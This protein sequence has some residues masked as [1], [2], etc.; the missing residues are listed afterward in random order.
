MLKKVEFQGEAGPQGGADGHDGF[1]SFA[2]RGT[3]QLRVD[4]PLQIADPAAHCGV[5]PEQPAGEDEAE[6]Q[7]A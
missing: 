5:G 6:Q 7:S 4:A 2:G 1:E 3:P